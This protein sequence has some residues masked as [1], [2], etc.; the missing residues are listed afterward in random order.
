MIVDKTGIDERKQHEENALTTNRT[1]HTTTGRGGGSP[2]CSAMLA[3]APGAPRPPEFE[4]ETYNTLHQTRPY[5]KKREK[6][7]GKERITNN[8]TSQKSGSL[9]EKMKV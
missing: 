4:L 5:R 7:K 9:S 8:K 1:I 3:G 2:L 6:R